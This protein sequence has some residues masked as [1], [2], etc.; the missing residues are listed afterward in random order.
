M[1]D[2]RRGRLP[3]WAPW[4]A[5]AAAVAVVLAAWAYLAG[6]EDEPARVASDGGGGVSEPMV[7]VTVPASLT[8]N[9]RDGQI[10]FTQNCAACHGPKAGGTDQGPP[11]VHRIYEPGHHADGAFLLAVRNGVRA[12]H[13]RFGDMPPRPGLRDVEVAAIVDYV[14]ALQKA[15]GIF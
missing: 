4:A 10:L 9:A 11:L 12:H 5:A 3:G 8:A 6:G 1:S 7:E 15:N 14:R 2:I 13:W